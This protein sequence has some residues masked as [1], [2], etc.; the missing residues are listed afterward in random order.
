MACS[1]SQ[2]SIITVVVLYRNYIRIYEVILTRQSKA[3]HVI[4]FPPIRGNFY[5]LYHAKFHISLCV[6]IHN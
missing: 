6:Y 3:A 1:K 4:S 2:Q 5:V